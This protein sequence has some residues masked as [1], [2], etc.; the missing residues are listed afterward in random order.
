MALA[1][2]ALEISFARFM[3]S[4]AAFSKERALSRR[5]CRFEP[6][7]SMVEGYGSYEKRCGAQAHGRTRALAQT[8]GHFVM[9]RLMS[10]DGSRLMKGKFYL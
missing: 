5:F 7:A 1:G 9:T 3:A 8:S 6:F 2:V 10:K 4:M